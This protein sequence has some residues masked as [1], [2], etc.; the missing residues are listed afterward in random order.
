MFVTKANVYDIR[1]LDVSTIKD[2]VFAIDTNVLYWMHYS[3][4]NETF[5][6]YQLE[7]YPDFLEDLLNNEN[8]LV[9]T[10]YNITELLYIIERNE[11][12]IYCI[13]NGKIKRK[14]FRNILSERIKVKNELN[15][16]LSQINSIYKIKNF[17]IEV[18]GLNDFVDNLDS[19]KC[20]DFDYLILKYL[21]QNDISKIITDDSDYITMEN[22]CV[23]TANNKAIHEAANT[24]KLVTG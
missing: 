22:I 7:A 20:D 8:R 9:T 11:Y 16:V 21:S 19:H 2:D 10:I 4:C 1:K 18:L 14:E 23:Y 12:D 3:R 5:D 15:T 6:G 13:Q 24:G 17:N